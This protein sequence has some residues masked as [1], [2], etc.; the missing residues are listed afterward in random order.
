MLIVEPRVIFSLAGHAEDQ[1]PLLDV[2]RDV[3]RRGRSLA[4][5]SP[6]PMKVPWLP[7]PPSA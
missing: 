5:A 1:G 3:D 6:S 4:A 2:E 7:A